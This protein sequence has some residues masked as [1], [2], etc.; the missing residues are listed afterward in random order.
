MQAKEQS[1]KG[2][3]IISGR[4]EERN[5]KIWTQTSRRSA[6]ATYHFLSVFAP[7]VEGKDVGALHHSISGRRR[8][9]F[10]SSEI[11]CRLREQVAGT[12]L[13]QTSDASRFHSS[14]SSVR[15]GRESALKTRDRKSRAL[16]R[17]CT[18]G[19]IVFH[20]GKVEKES[21][22]EALVSRHDELAKER[23][24]GATTM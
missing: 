15:R 6:L 17:G 11:R 7:I 21:K 1:M 16:E 18:L 13:N 8:S 19:S 9:V 20:P 12:R 24:K 23:K 10:W 22:M 5:E 14:R 4:N 3:L 2:K